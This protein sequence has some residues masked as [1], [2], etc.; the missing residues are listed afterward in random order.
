[1]SCLYCITNFFLGITYMY[2]LNYLINTLQ[3]KKDVR[4]Y[5]YHNFNFKSLSN[6]HVLCVNKSTETGGINSE[7]IYACNVS[8]ARLTIYY[9]S[10]RG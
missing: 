3:A 4:C 9:Y 1:M 10:E 5:Q 2:L 7:A 8:A 6:T